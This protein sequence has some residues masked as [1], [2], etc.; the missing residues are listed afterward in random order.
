MKA[1]TGIL[2]L[3]CFLLFL[4]GASSQTKKTVIN[5]KAQTVVPT[6]KISEESAKQIHEQ[7]QQQSGNTVTR[8]AYKRS[9]FENA[10]DKAG[11]GMVSVK[12]DAIITPSPKKE[13]QPENKQTVIVKP[14][15]KELKFI[16]G[17]VLERN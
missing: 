4:Q 2:T 15:Q 17:I 14:K 8:T 9:D 13:Q 10:A 3:F 11:H 16:E 6:K 7:Q 12:N 5:K 1:V